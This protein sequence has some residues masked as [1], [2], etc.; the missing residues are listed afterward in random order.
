MYNFKEWHLQ[1]HILAIKKK[2]KVEIMSNKIRITKR[3]ILFQDVRKLISGVFNC[4][5][6]CNYVKN[7]RTKLFMMT[8]G[9]M[10][11]VKNSVLFPSVQA[12]SG[13]RYNDGSSQPSL[14]FQLSL[15]PDLF[16]PGIYLPISL[17]NNPICTLTLLLVT[18]KS[19]LFLVYSGTGD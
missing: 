3:V 8:I 15:C 10:Q 19:C 16:V 9:Q 11:Q 5:Q 7:R 2:K 13:S 6:V 17:S 1:R 18:L 12:V 4:R 14:V